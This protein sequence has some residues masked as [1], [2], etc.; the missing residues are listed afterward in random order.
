VT[1]G[2]VD[3][4]T[5]FHTRA[6]FERL[7]ETSPA[8]GTAS[9]LLARVESDAG[10]EL[11]PEELSMLAE[12]WIAS[13][14]RGN[15][16][17]ALCLAEDPADRGALAEVASL[18]DD[19]LLPLAL[20]DPTEPRA[21]EEAR[22]LLESGAWRGIALAPALHHARLDEPEVEAVLDAIEDCAPL[23]VVFCGMLH[24]PWHDLFGHARRLRTDLAD[25]LHLVPAADRHPRSTFVLQGM[26]GG[27]LRETLI[28]GT[29]CPNVLVETSGADGWLF[30]QPAP[31]NLTDALSRVVSVFGH[32]RVLFGSGTDPIAPER[33][34]LE[35]GAQLEAL[36]AVGLDEAR[37]DAVF[38]GNARRLLGLDDA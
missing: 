11:P 5:W 18:A 36:G 13:L 28:A 3:G 38:G 22:E 31:M 12:H 16:Q 37:R 9:A 19:R 20:V 35:S 1:R 7:A 24:R 23:V 8:G 33:T 25:P 27:F 29:Q 14:H 32:E 15:V 34:R 26:G 4:L 2:L 17:H 6:W 21:A 30:T 10:I